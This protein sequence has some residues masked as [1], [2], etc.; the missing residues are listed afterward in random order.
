MLK[1]SILQ[2]K[3]GKNF[4]KDSYIPTDKARAFDEY[5]KV[6][7]KIEDDEQWILNRLNELGE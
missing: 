3:R 6:L 5:R 1:G 4:R 2:I 7:K